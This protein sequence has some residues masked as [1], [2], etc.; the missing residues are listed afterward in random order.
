[1]LSLA[2]YVLANLAGSFFCSLSEAALLASSEARIRARIEGGDPLARRL[3]RLKLDPGR[4]LA[5]IVFLNNVFAIA[6]TAAITAAATQVIRSEGG[7]AAFIAAQTL[8]IICFGEILPKI[9]GEALPEPIAGRVAPI[10][11]VLRRVLT[12]FLVMVNALVS[13]ARPRRRVISGREDEIR[14]LA[15][16]GEEGGHIH[17]QEADMIQRVFRL[18]D[19]TAG[20]VMT[21]RALVRG[22]RAAATLGEIRDELLAA[23]HY[24]FPVYEQDLDRVTGV[25][26]LRD[27]LAALAL[28]RAGT[29]VGELQK[30]A[31]FLPV[32][33]KV[34]LAFRD[35]QAAHGRMA[36]VLDEYG[37]TEGILTM[38]DLTEEI[39]GEAIDETDV[40]AGLVKRVSRDSALVHGLTRVRDVARFLKAPTDLSA[41]E[42]ETMTVTGL[43]QDRLDRIPQAGDEVELDNG[44]RFEVKVADER[45]AARVLARNLRHPAAP[46]A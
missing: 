12:P 14:Q 36:V 11:V 28:D 7:M 29:T 21:P 1:M 42:E 2:A 24:Q 25:L 26:Q 37:V 34:D 45:M 13:W 23:R 16:L 22:F 20:D 41:A 3:L 44:L 38:D 10:V 6:G 40:S 27:A 31:L 15:R 32:S 17:S 18:D 33:R 8:L 43:L 19:I 30:P 5:A 4:T 46:R 35:L 9:L 39:V